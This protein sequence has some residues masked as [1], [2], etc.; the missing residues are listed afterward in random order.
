MKFNLF[1]Y[2]PMINVLNRSFKVIIL[3][4]DN[5]M[6]KNSDIRNESLGIFYEFYALFLQ[7]NDCNVTRSMFRSVH[8]Y[9]VVT[10]LLLNLLHITS[11]A[12]LMMITFVLL[13][14]R[15]SLIHGASFPNIMT[16][17]H[18][19]KLDAMTHPFNFQTLYSCN[20]VVT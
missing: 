1:T 11:M 18:Y 13:K 9:L 2:R 15:C 17:S 16:K 12:V 10:L 5:L 7:V 8:L 6:N 3:H 20:N 4:P 14:K 19:C